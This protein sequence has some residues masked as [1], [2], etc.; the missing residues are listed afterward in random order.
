[1]ADEPENLT[2]RL[3]QEIRAE[4]REGFA[5][6]EENFAKVDARFDKLEEHITASDDENAKIL[7]TITQDLADLK[8]IFVDLQARVVRSEKRVQKLEKARPG[9]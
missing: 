2:I 7:E 6:V 5:K 1:M 4:M 8:T 9:A 3:L